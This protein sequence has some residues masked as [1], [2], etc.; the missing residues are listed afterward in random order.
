MQSVPKIGLALGSGGALGIAYIGILDELVKAKIP[1]YCITGSSIG[2][3]IGGMFAGGAT[4][5]QMEDFC[6]KL[7]ISS[8]IDIGF[9]GLGFVKGNK[10]VAQL[11][12]AMKMFGVENSVEKCKIK[13]GTVATNLL[14]AKTDYLTTGKLTDIMR[15]S[16]SIPGVFRPF[17]YNETLYVDG[18]PLCRV[19]VRLAKK[20]GAEYV[21]G[22]DCVG[23]T[24]K[25]GKDDI[26]KYGKVILRV[27]YMSDYAISHEEM[28]EANMLVDMHQKEGD[29]M[30]LK[31]LEQ[32]LEYGHK[33]G[34]KLVK[35]LKQQFAF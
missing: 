24:R 8:I 27:L 25:M 26:D 10:A 5:K 1:I 32:S 22:I 7:K 18:G 31:Y 34:K 28:M 30:S 9:G 14:T 2:A 3:V 16:F 13:F 21:V 23:A 20:L 17:E 35:D 11:E 15:A 29:P 12:K 33:Y 6:K 4:T 19:P